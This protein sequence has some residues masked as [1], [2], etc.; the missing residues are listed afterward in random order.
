MKQP[1][2]WRETID[3]FSIQFN[4]FELTKVLGYPHARN[5]VF[6]CKGLYDGQEVCCFVKHA[7]HADSDIAREISV[8]NALNFHFLPQVLDFDE[9][10]KFVVTK[11]VVGERLSVL[12]STTND[13]SIDYMFEYGKTLAQIHKATIACQKV[14]HR[15]FFDLPTIDQLNEY[16]IG[17]ALDYLTDNAPQTI[18]ECFCHGDFHYANI[19]W[20]NGKVTAVLDWELSGIGN[21]EFD[22]AWA[23]I[24]R[25]GQTFLNTDQEIVEFLK[26]YK[27]ENS[28]DTDKVKYYMIL[29]YCHFIAV[30]SNAEYK[31]F[32]RGWLKGKIGQGGKYE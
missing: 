22:I 14:A 18:D 4:N 7:R 5:D 15:K 10:G 20:N 32:V 17:F 8:I 27:S 28:C 3:P 19:L 9:Q 2:K 12:L 24:N 25:P 6:Y 23:I 30:G 29:I 21:K 16:G 13:K 11:E 26:G 1:D 31:D